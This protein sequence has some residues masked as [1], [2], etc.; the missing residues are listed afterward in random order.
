MHVIHTGFHGGAVIVKL[1]EV[2]F[3]HLVL[4]SG[5]EPWFEEFQAAI[6]SVQHR[7][8][9]YMIKMPV[10]VPFYNFKAKQFKAR[11]KYSMQPHGVS[12]AHG[13]LTRII[14]KRYKHL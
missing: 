7:E 14:T 12:R 6:I 1:W 2:L 5:E 11:I 10:G 9:E 4:V 13:S 3:I 8:F